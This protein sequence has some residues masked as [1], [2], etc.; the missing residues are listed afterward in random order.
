L[1]EEVK[2]HP[3]LEKVA[4]YIDKIAAVRLVA[5]RS[6]V[7]DS[8]RIAVESKV[9]AKRSD[10]QFIMTGENSAQGFIYQRV[11][12]ASF[13]K[14]LPT[15]VA[16]NPQGTQLETSNG[17]QVDYKGVQLGKDECIRAY[18]DFNDDKCGLLKQNARGKVTDMS[19]NNLDE[20]QKITVA[21]EQAKMLMSNLRP[22]NGSIIIRGKD[23][24][25][26]NRVFAALLLLKGA[27][28]HFKKVEIKSF[29]VGCEGP[30]GVFD[31]ESRFIKRHLGAMPAELRAEIKQEAGELNKALFSKNF[32]IEASATRNSIASQTGEPS[33]SHVV[34]DDEDDESVKDDESVADDESVQDDE[35][36]YDSESVQDDEAQERDESEQAPRSRSVSVP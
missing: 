31:T 9:V 6:T 15:Q 21:I 17:T 14:G 24:A 33:H 32:K 10:D 28:P 29:V 8:D 4:H 35:S 2:T 23:P 11:P 12:T 7:P 16:S 30:T 13:D 3:K 19:S 34:A 25:D 1:N 26:A 36:G 22:G 27:S 18:I 5:I 20:S